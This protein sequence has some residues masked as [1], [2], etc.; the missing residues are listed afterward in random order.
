MKVICLIL[1][2]VK[3]QIE[4]K[5]CS[6]SELWLTFDFAVKSLH[7]LLWYMETEPNSFGVDAMMF[8]ECS[9]YLEKFLLGLLFD[10]YSIVFHFDFDLIAEAFTVI[11]LQKTTKNLNPAFVKCKLNGVW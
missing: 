2:T 4:T 7:Y 8:V 3:H 10:T 5:S 11:R 1:A 9:K 6:Y